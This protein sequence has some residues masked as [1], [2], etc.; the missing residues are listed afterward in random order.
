VSVGDGVLLVGNERLE[1]RGSERWDFRIVSRVAADTQNGRTWIEWERGLGSVAPWV[2]PADDP[3][4]YVFRQRAALFGHNAPVWNLLPKDIQDRYLSAGLQPT[5]A[6]GTPTVPAPDDWPG[7]ELDPED[8][9]LHLDTLYPRLVAGTWMVLSTPE[10]REVYQLR[11]VAGSARVG[12]GLSAKTTMVRV[13]VLEHLK[14]FSIRDTVAFIQSEELPI[15]QAPVTEPVPPR[16][17][18]LDEEIGGLEAGRIL[19][20]RGPRARVRVAA[21][22]PVRED[23]AEVFR[24]EPGDVLEAMS[25]PETL[26]GRSRRVRLRVRDAGLRE[27][28]L[29]AP[30]RDVAFV[31]ADDD[32]DEMVEVVAIEEVEAAPGVRTRLM[33]D[34]PL[35]GVYDR[36]RF[37]L[38]GNVA[39][40]T[41]GEGKAE[42]LGSGDGTRE[43]Q[44][45][46][47]REAPLT[48][49]PDES[50]PSGTTTTLAVH[51][52][53]VAWKEVPTLFG[54]DPRD[55]VYTTRRRDDGTTVVQFGDG[56][57][58]ARLP[59][60]AENVEAVY[61]A[62][63]G[64][65]GNVRARQL[66]LLMTRPLGVR[67]VVN[68]LPATG[69]AE[70][71]TLDDARDAAPR[72]I[73]TMDRVVSLRD[74]EDFARGFAGVVK[75]QAVW[76]WDGGRRGVLVTVAGPDGDEVPEGGPVE[77]GLTAALG[78]FGDP[79]VPVRVRSYRRVRFRLEAAVVRRDEYRAG[80]VLR[81]VEEALRERFSFAPR[82]FGQRVWL[83]EVVAVMQSVAGVRAAN[84]ELLHREDA[85]PTLSPFLLAD[86]PAGG[87]DAALALPAE[88][89]TLD[90]RPDDVEVAA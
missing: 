38:L 54:R 27:G 10:Y 59:T 24:T 23:G 14:K 13:D 22:H 66:S 57:E 77:T 87:A 58:G 55:R 88:L 83:S 81:G 85:A 75:A 17:V 50:S 5:S 9:E 52:D 40:A 32:A 8:E 46:T 1:D 11:Y 25:Q 18:E 89:L 6:S 80:D 43:Y 37:R 30:A 63:I 70:P 42:R 15:A 65:V 64:R 60:G 79:H 56:R 33:L 34:P 3:R 41:H 73:L 28:T 51:V 7:L 82:R 12:F 69:G 4:L 19:V 21:A 20:A 26:D 16:H 71:Q 84:L 47:L 86:A 72:T 29:T 78:T 45:F 49:V 39:G 48:H 90:L 74:Y 61:R 68:P 2:M 76:T 35:A 44:R 31:E 62:G 67:G 53:G 36:T